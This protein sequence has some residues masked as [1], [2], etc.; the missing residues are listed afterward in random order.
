MQ[1]NVNVTANVTGDIINNAS[2]NNNNNTAVIIEKIKSWH[3][4]KLWM[5][6]KLRKSGAL[7]FRK[8]NEGE[9]QQ[10]QQQQINIIYKVVESST[11]GSVNRDPLHKEFTPSMLEFK[12]SD[13]IEDINNTN[14]RTC[15]LFLQR[16]SSFSVV[17]LGFIYLNFHHLISNTSDVGSY[18]K[19]SD[20]VTITFMLSTNSSSGA[21]VPSPMISKTRLSNQWNKYVTVGKNFYMLDESI[22]LFSSRER[23]SSVIGVVDKRSMD[24]EERLIE[25]I[26]DD[27]DEE[28]VTMGNE[29][30]RK[31]DEEEEEE[32]DEEEDDSMSICETVKDEQNDDF[33]FT[34]IANLFV[35]YFTTCKSL[36]ISGVLPEIITTTNSNTS[37]KLADKSMVISKIPWAERI[38][39][40]GLIKSLFDK[41][42]SEPSV[43]LY[44]FIQQYN[45]D[46][47]IHHN[48]DTVDLR[49]NEFE[50]TISCLIAFAIFLYP[51]SA[52]ATIRMYNLAHRLVP[53]NVMKFIRLIASTENLE[54]CEMNDEDSSSSSNSNLMGM[55]TTL[56]ELNV[57]TDEDLF[58]S[59]ESL[60]SMVTNIYLHQIIEPVLEISLGIVLS[61]LKISADR[62]IDK[63]VGE[64]DGDDG[65]WVQ[66]Q[67]DNK[68]N[69][70]FALKYNDLIGVVKREFSDYFLLKF[71][72]YKNTDE[73]YA[74]INY[75]SASSSYVAT[76]ATNI[77]RLNE[78]TGA[79]VLSRDLLGNNPSNISGGVPL[80]LTT[81]KYERVFA[82]K[83]LGELAWYFEKVVILDIKSGGE[84][85]DTY[86][87][88][89]K[90]RFIKSLKPFSIVKQQ[91][92]GDVN[93]E[94][95]QQDNILDIEDIC[96]N[97]APACIR[98]VVSIYK[99]SASPLP[100]DYSTN[101]FLT[102]SLINTF[103]YLMC[104][105]DD[106]S[107]K[108]TSVPESSHRVEIINN[109]NQWLRHNNQM[110]YINIRS[111]RK[112]SS[113]SDFGATISGYLESFKKNGHLFSRRCVCSP[114]NT[115]S[116]NNN[117]RYESSGDDKSS[118]FARSKMANRRVVVGNNTTLHQGEEVMIHRNRGGST[119]LAPVL[120]KSEMKY[121]CPHLPEDKTSYTIED[122]T[123]AISACRSEMT[124][125]G[126]QYL[127]SSITSENTSEGY[128]EHP[129]VLW[130]SQIRRR[131]ERELITGAS[132][133]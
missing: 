4:I 130:A 97:S 66:S 40:D 119:D 9:D 92:S 87:R 22:L 90:K 43:Y 84:F 100:F 49:Q 67:A 123:K 35:E 69:A 45:T 60:T 5:I 50:E 32:D 70:L 94:Q 20:I 1:H 102:N 79:R 31:R 7:P 122:R 78:E 64:G 121:T 37:N 96:S 116:A 124:Y 44:K 73:F 56:C 117:N 127:H 129:D 110:R 76:V 75:S 109:I 68:R 34:C 12:L 48:L 132:L 19:I 63:L 98:Q 104:V 85:T 86:E 38:N 26:H 115:T 46:E 13:I 17:I 80:P 27:E 54:K 125:K 55:I 111:K 47:L 36:S 62:S 112:T 33:I 61:R 72:M 58:V 29:R 103:A 59:S 18:D 131:K 118:R 10:Q 71:G 74:S 25:T 77:H 107:H 24:V 41:V 6:S 14:Q 81:S 83:L 23:K 101:V 108:S 95:H 39:L 89:R 120:H 3:W 28:E 106:G 8:I 128:Q 2:N 16:V 82:N 53:S 113:G 99:D 30:K 91:H 114:E 93:D 15:V 52:W 133:R 88:L 11:N 126:S 21:L 105:T 51:Y 57:I 65:V 42:A